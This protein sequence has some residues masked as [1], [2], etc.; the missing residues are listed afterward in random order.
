MKHRNFDVEKVR[1]DIFKKNRVTYG[2]NI[3]NKIA[4]I[5]SI[6]LTGSNM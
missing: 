3:S 5:T 2:T 6:F 4:E 1:I